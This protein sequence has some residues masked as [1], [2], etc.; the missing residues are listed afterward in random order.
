MRRPS[1]AKMCSWLATRLRLIRLTPS[2]PADIKRQRELANDAERK[3]SE[4]EH[5][6]AEL[7]WH[8][9]SD[10]DYAFE[11]IREYDA[12]HHPETNAW[13]T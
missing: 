10:L 7:G 2:N 5:I 3:I 12:A 4:L 9:D 13:P 8:A 11:L 6:A 1:R